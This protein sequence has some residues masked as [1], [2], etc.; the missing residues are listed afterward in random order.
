MNLS[1]GCCGPCREPQINGFGTCND[2][3]E[4]IDEFGYL[5][6]RNR[7]DIIL[8]EHQLVIYIEHNLVPRDPIFSDRR[9]SSKSGCRQAVILDSAVVLQPALVLMAGHH[10]RRRRIWIALTKFQVEKCCSEVCPD[11][12]SSVTL[13]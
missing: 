13:Q 3:S 11:H 6:N 4:L 1:R 5:S 2:D 7:P 10:R 9:R 8:F 12:Q